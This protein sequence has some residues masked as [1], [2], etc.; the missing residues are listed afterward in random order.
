MSMPSWLSWL[1][2][3]GGG[4]GSTPTVVR[5]F[6]TADQTVSRDSIVVQGDGWLVDAPEGRVV[7]LFEIDSPGLEQCQLAYRAALKCEDLQGRAYLEM[8][9]R[10]PGKGEFFSK[11]LNQTLKGTV[12]WSTYEIPFRLKKGQRPDLIKL[13][14]AVEGRGKVWVKDVELLSTPK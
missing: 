9:C 3:G 7:R 6:T 12:D 8:W 1:K 2:P 14:L 5:R 4:G 10:L 11:G 13:N